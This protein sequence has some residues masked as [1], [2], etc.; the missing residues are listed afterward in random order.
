MDINWVKY[1]GGKVPVETGYRARV[2]KVY[3]T[4]SDW[5]PKN[6]VPFFAPLVHLGLG[7][8][9]TYLRSHDLEKERVR[10]AA[11][12]Y[13]GNMYGLNV[14]SRAKFVSVDFVPKQHINRIWSPHSWS[15]EQQIKDREELND[16]EFVSLISRLGRHHIL[17][18]LHLWTAHRAGCFAF[19]TVDSKF[20]RH[21][22]NCNKGG[23]LDWLKARPYL[24]SQVARLWRIRPVSVEHL[25]PLNAS[26]PY[27]AK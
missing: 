3:P 15:K 11:S 10:H 4:S 27:H 14:W 23:K 20:L 22:E 25:T 2:P 26:F 12:K 21:F 9:V 7:G 24:P 13:V 1:W 17:D 18:C 5:I 19:L 16:A 8:Y 6:E